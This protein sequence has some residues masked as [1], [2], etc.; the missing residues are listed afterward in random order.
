[1]I[2]K[3][4]S[5]FPLAGILGLALALLTA[6]G[7]L[8][9]RETDALSGMPVATVNG[10]PV[11]RVEYLRALTAMQAGLS[12]PLTR[13]DKEKAL[14][15]LI[16]EEVILQ[17][18]LK[19]GLG[20]SDP[21]ARKNLVQALMRSTALMADHEADEE[22]LKAFFDDNR[23]LFV[24]PRMV[25]VQVRTTGDRTK[26]EHFRQAVM[27]GEAFQAAALRLQLEEKK[28]PD[29]IPLGKAADYL[30]GT[31][32]DRLAL[33]REGDIVGPLNT[34][35]PAN[36]GYMFIWLV[37]ATRLDTGFAEVSEQVKAE[38]QRRREEEAFETYLSN[39]RETA[40]IRRHEDAIKA[41]EKADAA[42]PVAGMN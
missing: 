39:L 7:I 29:D 15:V 10:K 24:P 21:M 31:A 6:L 25:R 17:H 34:G 5:L 14:Q 27:E 8:P 41:V 26:A 33:L 3:S 32:R 30:G 42:P 4:S 1:M 22:K 28:L 2:V 16:D 38:W 20:R 18:A 19:I 37:K 12:R 9:W 36:P 23:H 40:D 11:G 35:S 13:A